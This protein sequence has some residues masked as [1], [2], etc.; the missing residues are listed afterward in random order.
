MATVEG[1]CFCGAVRYRIGAAPKAS[2]VC[3]CRSCRR[4]A[5][6]PAVPW[7]TV[8]A[9]A[10]AL[11]AGALRFHRSSPPVRRGFCKACGTPL[12]YQHDGRPAD[13]DVTTAS[14]DDPEA[15]P[16]AY[17]V[18]LGDELTWVRLGDSLPAYRGWKSEG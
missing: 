8:A 14:L 4:A 7:I 12:T 15:F 11:S 1:G 6:A 2:L 13:I 3:H 5:A 18:Q 17:H 9:D 10:F 16:P